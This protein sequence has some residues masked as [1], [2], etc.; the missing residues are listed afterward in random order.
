MAKKQIPAPPKSIG[1]SGGK[2]WR[3]VLG[4]FELEEHELALL[5]EMARTVDRLDA[6][7]AITAR[8]GFRWPVRM[9]RRRIGR[10][11]SRGSWGSCLCA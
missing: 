5:K 7:A 11:P 10:R 1:S 9:A 2:L 3:D 8:E 4:K 6:L